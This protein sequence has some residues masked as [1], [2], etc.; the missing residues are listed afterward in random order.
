MEH[1]ITIL[2][3]AMIA[4]PIS[5]PGVIIS[6]RLAEAFAEELHSN[7]RKHFWGYSPDENLNTQDLHRVRYHGIRPAPGYPTQPDHTEKSTMWRLMDVTKVT[8]IELTDSLAMRPAASVS[9]LYFANPKASY[10]S[11]GKI[12]KEQVMN[13]SK[14]KGEA[15]ESME[16]WLGP[17]LAYT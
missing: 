13:Y 3:N 7:V 2:G 11:V 9:G 12:T 14:R 16:T 5:Y 15:L 1:K 4:Y 6:F 8:G 10:F 17:I